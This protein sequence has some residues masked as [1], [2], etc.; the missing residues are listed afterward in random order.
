MNKFYVTFGQKYHREIHPVLGDSVDPDGYCVVVAEN[1]KEAREKT[2][3]VF[4]GFFCFIYGEEEFEP[5][6]FPHGAFMEI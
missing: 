3:E 4:G 2:F 6:F 1:E 5:E